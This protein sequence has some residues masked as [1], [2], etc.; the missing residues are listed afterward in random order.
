VLGKP[1]ANYPDG[2]LGKEGLPKD[3]WGR[4]FQYTVLENGARY[5]LWSTGPDGVDQQGAGDDLV[6]P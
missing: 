1:T 4:A 5:R 2:F 3:G 6:S